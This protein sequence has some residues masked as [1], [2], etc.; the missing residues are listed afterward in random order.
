[1]FYL[2][3]KD[4]QLKQQINGA[5]ELMSTARTQMKLTFTQAL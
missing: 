3:L 1:M 5:G 4:K 2:Y